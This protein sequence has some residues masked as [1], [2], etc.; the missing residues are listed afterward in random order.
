MT[1]EVYENEQWW[2]MNGL[3]WGDEVERRRALQPLYSIQ[4]VFLSDYFSRVPKGTKV[5]EFGVGFGRHIEYLSDL[6]NIEIYGVDQ[7]ETMLESLRNNLKMKKDLLDRIFL[8]EPRSKL[9][10]P[11]GYFDIV[12]TVSVL[13]HIRPEHLKGILSELIRVTKHG[14]LHFENNQVDHSFF[15]TEDHNGCW[16]HSLVNEYAALNKK[17]IVLDKVAMEQDVYFV[18]LSGDGRY[19]CFNHSTVY[20]RLYRLDSKILPKMRELEGEIGWRT[21]ELQERINIEAALK[22]ELEKLKKNNEDLKIQYTKLVDSNDALEKEKERLLDHNKF[23]AAEMEN[24]N[25]QKRDLEQK[26]F[27]IKDDLSRLETEKYSLISE[28]EQL[29]SR[30]RML[31]ADVNRFAATI[32]EIESSLAWKLINRFRRMER[33]YGMTA[34]LRRFIKARRGQA[35]MDRSNS[36]SSP[37]PSVDL[38]V[39]E[40][41]KIPG[42][43][44]SQLER[45]P[46]GSDIAI[47]QPE[48]LGVSNSTKELFENVLAVK[49]LHSFNDCKKV[50]EAI[51]KLKPRSITFSGFAI[52]YAE[53][54]KLIKQ[55]L[56]DT[57]IAVFWHG[58]TT[59][60]YEDYSWERHQEILELYHQGIIERFGFAKECM[61]KLY[62]AKGFNSHFVMNSVTLKKDYTPSTKSIGGKLR[63]GLYASGN[64]WNKNAYTQIAAASLIDNAILFSIPCNNRMKQFAEQLNVEIVGTYSTVP[65]EEMLQQMKNN[66]INLYVTFS[67]CAPLLPLESLELGVP[68]LTGPNHHYFEEYPVLKDYLVVSQPDNPVLIAEKIKAAI[69]NRDKILSEYRTWREKNNIL[70][71]SSVDAFLG[72]EV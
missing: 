38:T 6:S 51:I 31:E 34:P 48:W 21:A 41:D 49:E 45:I 13:I 11:D 32:E 46:L 14:I 71:R 24:L 30:I 33:L 23:L 67:E 62:A 72:R 10:F 2:R 9:P 69:E 19:E 47:H 20:Q 42:I 58:N 3:T 66:D 7:S 18:S 59:H 29:Y 52:G 4:E 54:A 12:Y 50:A 60:M 17:C 70:S 35:V 43:D 28:R 44:H 27:E 61:A 63:I 57:M 40:T 8:I 64:T 37:S 15:K 55:R 65:R 56:P 16:A 68:C 39:P 25:N 26:F 36:A 22:V 1:V 5:L 53:L